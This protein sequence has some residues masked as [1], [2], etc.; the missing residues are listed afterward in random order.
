MQTIILSSAFEKPKL[1]DLEEQRVE[2]VRRF[3]FPRSENTYPVF[4]F[5]KKWDKLLATPG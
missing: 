3:L 1:S 2:G 5:P 4:E